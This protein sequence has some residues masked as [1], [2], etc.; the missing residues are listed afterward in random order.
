MSNYALTTSDQALTWAEFDTE[1]QKR[2][3]ILKQHGLGKHVIMVLADDKKDVFDFVW[4]YAIYFNG[5]L[6]CPMA[7]RMS[8]MELSEIKQGVGVNAVIHKGNLEILN[9]EERDTKG[10][11]YI[12]RTGGSTVKDMFEYYPA[13]LTN[14]ERQLVNGVGCVFENEIQMWRKGFNMAGPPVLAMPSSFEATFVA[15]NICRTLAMGGQFHFVDYED[16]FVADVKKYGINLVCSYPNAIKK[17]CDSVKPGEVEIPYWEISGGATPIDLLEDIRAKFNPKVI[18]NAI[19]SQES[20]YTGYSTVG[21]DDP[22]EKF[23]WFEHHDH[24]NVDIKFEDGLLYYKYDNHDWMTDNDKVEV[25]DQGRFKYTGRGNDDYITT[26]VGVK[27]YTTVTRA[28]VHEVSGV[29]AAYSFIDLDGEHRMIYS[30]TA[31]IDRVADSLLELQRYKR[32]KTLYKVHADFL[33]LGDPKFAVKKIGEFLR[34]NQS[35]VQEGK[36]L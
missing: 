15:I 10:A 35:L 27:V 33:S 2:I 14:R 20:D 7:S 8:D 26:Q 13:W 23:Y 12:S 36:E 30:G 25:D 11:I 16:D 28:K 9:L 22:L 34:A 32:P 19:G 5:G 6:C 3:E 31:D 21:P 29:D 24:L 4:M 1:V 18:M 17:L